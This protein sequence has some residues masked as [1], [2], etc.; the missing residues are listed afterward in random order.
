MKFIPQIWEDKLTEKFNKEC[1]RFLMSQGKM[2][3]EEYAEG[4]SKRELTNTFRGFNIL[5][6]K[7]KDNDKN[8]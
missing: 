6:T 4:V 7:K 2:T 3:K 1:V 8:D 5:V